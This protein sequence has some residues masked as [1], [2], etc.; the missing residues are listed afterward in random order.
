MSAGDK[1]VLAGLD[2]RLA[3]REQK[4]RDI[5]EWKQSHGDTESY[6]LRSA[7][8]NGVEAAREEIAELQAAQLKGGGDR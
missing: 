2:E 8:A 3:E 5:A 6:Q 1:D 7:W 4:A